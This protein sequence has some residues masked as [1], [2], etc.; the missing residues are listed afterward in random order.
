MYNYVFFPMQ[1]YIKCK[2]VSYMSS[3]QEQFYDIQLNIKGKKD[4]EYGLQE[5][6]PGV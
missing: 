4:S 5:I 3:R 2:H 1:S 6:L